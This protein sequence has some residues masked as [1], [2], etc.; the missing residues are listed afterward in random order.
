LSTGTGRPDVLY[1]LD[2]AP[3]SW[4]RWTGSAFVQLINWSDSTGLGMVA[5]AGTL[6]PVSGATAWEDLRF[7]A[8]AINPSGDTAAASIIIDQ[9][10]LPGCLSFSGSAVNLVAGVCQMPHG[11]KAGTAIKPHI[12]WLKPTGSSSAVSWT[13]ET[14]VIGDPA[15]VMGAWSDPVAGTIAKGTQTVSNNHLLSS[16]GSLDMTGLDASAMLAWRLKRLGDTD[17]DS[18]AVT[19]LEFDV[20]YQADKAGTVAEFN[21]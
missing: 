4:H 13:L 2:S 7:P 8:H 18:N 16:F 11:W 6:V 1:V 10:G 5:P 19:L 17:A 9:N 12:H 3:F 14:R 15:D 20:H 21:A